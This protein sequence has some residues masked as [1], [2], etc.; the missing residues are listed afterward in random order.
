[1][2]RPP[3]PPFV[4]ARTRPARPAAGP[5]RRPA[6]GTCTTTPAGHA[7]ATP[8]R[9][10]RDR[11]RPLRHHLPD[12]APVRARR[13]CAAPSPITGRH[14]RRGRAAGR[15]PHP[16][17]DRRGELPH[18]QR[19]A[20]R[21]RPVGP[22]C[23]AAG[24]H[25][26][27][28]F[29]AERRR[30][31]RCLAGTLTVR[32]SPGRSAC[33]AAVTACRRG[34][35]RPG[36]RRAS[37]GPSSA[38][39][40]AAAWPA[41]TSTCPWRSSA[42][43]AEPR[44]PRRRPAGGAAAA[45]RPA[46]RRRGR[47][48]QELRRGGGR[49]RGE[50][51]RRAAGEIFAL[52]GPNGAG[53]TTIL[54]ILEGFRGRDGG[55]VDVLGLDPGDRS[56]GRALRERIGLVLQDIAVEPYLTVR[57]TV[58]RNAGYY[59]APR[60]VGEVIAPGRPGRAGAAEGPRPVRRPEAA[61]GPGPG[62]GRQPGAA[63]PGR[64][65]DRVR[66][67]RPPGRLGDGAR[68]ARRGHHG[69]AHHALHGRGPGAGRPGG[70]DVRRPDRGRGH[71]GHHRRPGHGP[72]PDPLRPARRAPPCRPAARRGGEPG[73]GLVTV[74]TAE[75]TGALHELTGWALGRGGRWTGSRWTS[76]AWKTSTCA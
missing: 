7:A 2:P 44:Q 35:S 75:P 6:L 57:E 52:L 14:G 39:P 36:R 68:P 73:D 53:K 59:P 51:H 45:V 38:S 54:E 64:A 62:P 60:D 23:S 5:P 12:P 32:A 3:G 40:P 21:R 63:V 67:E 30:R 28:T 34:R 13:R 24:Q 71:P 29:D 37:T 27:I 11:P 9:P 69:P 76:P 42:Y 61:A 19:P 10:L 18:R 48:A 58:A 33:V 15:V 49:A 56:S 50:L 4:A 66:P 41:A 72:G 43:A 70:G 16:R 46:A 25:P 20:G 17:G 1:M 47:A 74:E 65:D 8:A 26:V 31:V 55:Q 22:A